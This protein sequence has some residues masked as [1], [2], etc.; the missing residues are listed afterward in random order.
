MKNSH[1][2]LNMLI[3][4]LYVN[5]DSSSKTKNSRVLQQLLDVLLALNEVVLWAVLFLQAVT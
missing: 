3:F 4:Y 5:L 2:L 1:K